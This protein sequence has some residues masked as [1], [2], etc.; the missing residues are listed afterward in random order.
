MLFLDSDVLIDLLER[1]NS[2][3]DKI[4][5][6]IEQ[7]KESDIRI[8]SIVLEEVL[9]GI[10]KRSKNQDLENHPIYNFPVVPFGKNEAVLA[11]KIE[12]E[13]EKQ[14]IK[15]PRIDVFVAVTAIQQNA[16]LLTFNVRHYQGIPDLKLI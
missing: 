8:S 9:F 1:K 6:I 5:K 12:A 13:M 15:K 2:K 7:S 14:G 4:I 11:A 10:I 3:S 16:K